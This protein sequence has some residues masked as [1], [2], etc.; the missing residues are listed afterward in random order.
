MT[1][2]V[3]LGPPGFPGLDGKRGRKGDK[4]SAMP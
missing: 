3:I 4:V 2:L 1:Y